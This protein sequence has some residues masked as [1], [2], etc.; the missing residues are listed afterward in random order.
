VAGNRRLGGR[1]PRRAR[2][3]LGGVETVAL[4][5]RILAGDNVTLAEAEAKHDAVD[6]ASGGLLLT[7]LIAGV[8]VIVWAYRARQNAAG[9]TVS[10]FRRSSGWAIGGWICPIVSLW[11]PYQV[12]KDIWTASDTDRP[13]D[14]AVK[15][16]RGTVVIPLWWTCF[17]GGSVLN[18]ISAALFP[19]SEDTVKPD[20]YR[21]SLMFD[22]AAAAAEIAAA[23]MF[24]VIVAAVTRLQSQRYDIALAAR[25]PSTP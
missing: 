21:V 12:V 6:G 15:A 16:W 3:L 5:D 22:Y 7:A 2:A 10:P 19:S 18:R 1:D 4:V 20:D 9:Y 24:V 23:I 17:I 11:F 14:C 13:H 25:R 8:F